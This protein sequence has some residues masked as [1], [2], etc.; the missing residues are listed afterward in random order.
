MPFELG[1]AVMED[2]RFFVLEE[3]AYRLQAS[4]S[5]LNGFD[6]LI[7]NGNPHR[8]LLKLK[9]ALHSRRYHPTH[10]QLVSVYDR[11]CRTVFEQLRSTG[12]DLFSRSVFDDA[13]R[14]AVAECQ[15]DG[16]I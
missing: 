3:R 12:A 14:L 4:L 5:D 11:V 9:D 16:L 6:P 13:C 15:I 8:V 10:A 7:H 2:H 1:L